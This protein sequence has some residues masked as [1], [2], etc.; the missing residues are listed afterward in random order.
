M[1]N[2]LGSIADT[3]IMPW[4]GDIYQI[5]GPRSLQEGWLK[6]TAETMIPTPA[7]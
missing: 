7:L 4:R 2:T 1:F 3:K 5:R 6:L